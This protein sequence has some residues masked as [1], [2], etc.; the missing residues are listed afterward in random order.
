VLTGFRVTSPAWPFTVGSFFCSAAETPK[1]I[2][3]STVPAGQ[4]DKD[5]GMQD[6]GYLII[7]TLL[8]RILDCLNGAVVPTAPNGSDP[9]END[10]SSAITLVNKGL[11]SRDRVNP[12]GCNGV[13]RIRFSN[14][15]YPGCY[16]AWHAVWLVTTKNFGYLIVSCRHD[17]AG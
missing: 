6:A 11:V 2:L 7:A 15:C 12:R 14:L 5:N 3:I 10:Y 16:G 8:E 4:P 17:G 1:T 13:S 9:W